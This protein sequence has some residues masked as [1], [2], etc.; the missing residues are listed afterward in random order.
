MKF[1]T[2]VCFI[3]CGCML[4]L[5]NAPVLTRNRKKIILICTWLITLSAILTL[6]QYIFNWNAGIDEFLWKEGA[7]AT[8]TNYPGRMSQITALNFIF[9]GFI[10]LTLQQRKFHWFIQVLLTAIIPTSLLVIL[11]HFFGVSFLSS[12]P[13]FT[14][15]ALHTAILFIMLCAGIFFSAPLQHLRFSFQKKTGAVF[16][17]TILLLTFIFFAINK[18]NRRSVLLNQHTENSREIISEA[19]QV[20]KQTAEMQSGAALYLLTGEENYLPLF[21]NSAA[22]IYNS[23]KKLKTISQGNNLQARVNEVDKIVAGYILLKKELILLCQVKK[24]DGEKIKTALR[25]DRITIEKLDALTTVIKN[26]E[27]KLI[28]THQAEYKQSMKNSNR[29]ILLFQFI[30]VLLFITAF[31]II[32]RNHR[33]RNKAEEEIKV[34]NATLEKRVLEKTKEVNDKETQYRFLLQN[35]REGIMIIGYDWRYLFVNDAIVRQSKYSIRELLGYTIMEKFP[36]IENRPVFSVLKRCMNEKRAEVTE[37]NYT[38]PDG[39][40]KWFELSIQPVPEG[41]FILSMDIT[42]RKKAAEEIKKYNE[43]FK[44]IASTTYDGIWEWNLDTNELW[45]NEMHQRLYG[46][47]LADAVPAAAEWQQ[48]IHPGDRERMISTQAAA[49]T[50]DTNVFISEYLFKTNNGQYINMYDRCYI[51][52]NAAGTPIRMTGSMMDITE[53]KKAEEDTRQ[54]KEKYFNLMNS[55]EGIVW[56]AD[57]KTFE[58]SFV[59]QQAERLLGYP[60]EQWTSQPGFWADH[61]YEEDRNDTVNFCTVSTRQ[62][63]P[64]EFEYRMVAADGRLI[65]LRDIVSVLVEND[66][67]KK[68]N[69][70]MVDI[71]ERKKDELLLQE[72]NEALKKK[73]A[74]LQASNTE[75]ERFA[76][77]ASHDLQEPLR[78]VS[79]FMNL[80]EKRMDGQLD[81]TTKQYIYFAADGAM[82][83]KELI[84]ALLQYS[85][86]GANKEDFSLTDL[87][88][89]LQYTS[90]VL[91]NDIKKLGAVIILNPLPAAMADKALITQL[92]INLVSNALK[93]NTNKNPVVEVN[94]TQDIDQYTF[95]VK[96]N[97]IGIDPKFFDKIFIIFQRL[98]AKSEYSGTGI[99][100][101]ICK[102]IVELHSGNI[103]VESEAGAGSIF[104]FSIPKQ[105]I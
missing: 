43:R 80:L 24:C 47:T 65:W 72:L 50:S 61:I 14:N 59:S 104:Y 78:M 20:L 8:A 36:G 45:A 11:N 75:L 25:D 38:F 53:R 16:V 64:H 62:K 70:I 67:A 56:E 44:L 97:G 13:Q 85:R 55:V 91:E 81:E 93:Y 23:I 51:V 100:L 46:L 101:A 4:F 31:I 33:L 19:N 17:F 71:T 7:E 6:S 9:F 10:F 96:D 99:G 73:A 105:N 12:I 90:H 3:L 15:T 30:T 40:N 89:V 41:L 60:I 83:M 18:S 58:F 35:M 1:N 76:Y 54:L 77:I 68:I 2:A 88:E 92:F 103:W 39:T 95:Y 87:N 26:N 98:H 79:S 22:L 102:K 94:F 57:A 49:L 48:R 52:R 5:H 34:L 32:Y 27:F 63:K 21:N 86:V 29:I 28:A 82:R 84:T 69:G 37:S 66:E 42:Q 74:E